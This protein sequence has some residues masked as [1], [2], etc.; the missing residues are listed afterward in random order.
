M[1]A[2]QLTDLLK[3]DD[4]IAVSNI[5]GREASKV[6]IV[7]QRYCGNIVGGWALGKGGQDIEYESGKTIP[8]FATFDELLNGLPK[9][10]HPNKLVVYSPPDAVYGEVKEIISYGGKQIETI[11]II[12]EHVSIEVT[13]KIAN[14]AKEAGIDVIGC[15][16]L[17][18]INTYDAVRV[19]AVGGDNPEESFKKGS[20]AIISNS[21]NMVTTM[22]TYLLSAGIG[23]S[24]G[25]STGK[26]VLILKPLQEFLPLAAKDKHTRLLVLYVEPGGLYEKEAVEALS[27][28]NFSKPI[29]VY[30]A[31]RILETQNV[32]LGHAGAVVEGSATTATAKMKLFDDYFGIECFD[33]QKR[34]EPAGKL[35][36]ALQ[37]G[38]RIQALHHLPQAASLIFRSLSWERDFSPR[39]MIHL[40]PWFLNLGDLGKKLPSHLILHAGTIIEP[41]A[42]QFASLAE[43]KLGKLSTQRSMRHASYASAND[44]QTTTIYGY[45]ATDLMKRSGFAESLILQWLGELPQHHFE[46]KLVEMCL[47]ASLSNGPGTIS[48]QGAKLSASAGNQPHTGM[49]AALASVGQ[50][51]GGNGKEA[52]EY[53]VRIFGAAELKDPYDRALPGI[54]LEELVSREAEWFKKQKDAAQE[55]GTAYER[56]P[57]LGHPVFKDKDV[58]YDPR[59]QVICNYLKEHNLF[60][61]F[62]EFYHRLAETLK[63]IGATSKVL[64]V[65]VDAAIACIWL[66]ICWKHLVEKR[67]TLKRA[68]DIPLVAFALGRVAGAA[69]E[70]LDHQDHGTEMDM[71]V[72]PS[73]CEI[74][75]KPRAFPARSK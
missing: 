2:T 41:Y 34:Y 57:C 67:I 73:E 62:L 10:Q 26:D 54:E 74:L 33:P 12:T 13:A 44:G 51:H 70:F 9:K 39:G 15:N 49:I 59:E 20:A 40:N 27:R 31:G 43:S 16:T 48:A 7:S 36:E 61:V 68:V 21:G 75:T 25:I 35:R 38:I 64:A 28:E 72:P 47:V 4:R 14:L 11:F 37:R 19:G 71:R 69:G 24:F 22:A 45:D 42:S 8:V 50:V 53:L 17:G 18:M 65:N 23:T 5:T 29:V 66:G 46:A 60:N 63:R 30:V 55:S 3:K 58:N 6:S 1:K 56:I 32:S 52:V